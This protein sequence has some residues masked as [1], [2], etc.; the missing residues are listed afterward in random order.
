[1]DNEDALMGYRKFLQHNGNSENVIQMYYKR[2]RTFLRVRPEA[3]EADKENLRQIIDDYIGS[4]SFNTGLG[5]TATAVRYFWVSLFGARYFKRTQLKDFPVN[6]E[7]EAE[8]K[9]FEGYL[10]SLGKLKEN[11][12]MPRVRM[13]RLFLY[14][15]YGE[16]GFAREK[17]TADIVRRHISE[18]MSYVSASTKSGFSS[19]IRSYASF[20]ELQ[21]YEGNARAILRLPLRG[22]MRRSRLPRCISDEDFA[23]LLEATGGNGGARGPR[24]KAML[25][26][27]GNLGLRSCDVASLTLDDV[28]WE[29]GVIHVRNSKSIADRAIPLDSETGAAIEAYVIDTRKKDDRMRALFLPG[30]NEVPGTGISFQQIGRRIRHIAK[31]AGI[32]DYCGTHSLRRS[33]ATNMTNN[34]VPIK[35]IADI[36]GHE[37]AATTMGYL[38]VN[39]SNLRRACSPWPEGGRL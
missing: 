32:A 21:G 34:G 2:V 25:L 16:E 38:R 18:T 1:M 6:Q 15:Q 39:I 8:A 10:R 17:V 14:C 27:M 36:L 13:V 28:E 5:V 26:L 19:N 22:P 35:T 12:I 37:D 24:D 31:K 29:R 20:L 7:I 23:A 30:G 9:A 11:T 3:L 33:A 4:L